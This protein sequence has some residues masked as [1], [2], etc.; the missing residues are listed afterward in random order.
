MQEIID[1]YIKNV[2]HPLTERVLEYLLENHII[3]ELDKKEIDELFLDK[4]GDKF[5]KRNGR[6]V[7]KENRINAVDEISKLPKKL[8]KNKFKLKLDKFNK[9]LLIKE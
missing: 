2:S 8:K 1:W 6:F 3:N 7:M 5:I 4:Y 9:P